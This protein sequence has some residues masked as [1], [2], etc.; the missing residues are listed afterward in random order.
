MWGESVDASD[1]A[2]TV[3]PRL[4]AERGHHPLNTTTAGVIDSTSEMLKNQTG[5]IHEQAAS[6]GIT[7]DIDLDDVDGPFVTLRCVPPCT[8]REAAEKKGRLLR[9]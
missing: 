5:Q 1:L 9:V 3:W 4:A 8:E 2:Q 7:G 6:V